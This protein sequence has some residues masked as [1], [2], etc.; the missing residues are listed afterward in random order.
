MKK[1][2]KSLACLQMAPASRN[3]LVQSLVIGETYKFKFVTPERQGH[4]SILRPDDQTLNQIFIIDL[5][6]IWLDRRATHN[7]VLIR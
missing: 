1:N 4:I 5:Y 3:I 6:H 7:S 2:Q